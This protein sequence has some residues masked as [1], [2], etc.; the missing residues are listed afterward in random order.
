MN[1]WKIIETNFDMKKNALQESI[2]SLGNGFLGFRGN[3]EEMAS[4]DGTYINGFYETAEMY[5]EEHKT[6]FAKNSETMLNVTAAKSVELSVCG[7]PFSMLGGEVLEHKRELDMLA[8][9]L[10]RKTHWRSPQGNEITLRSRR[11]V[12]FTDKNIAAF[13]YEVTAENFDGYL[14]IKTGVDGDVRNITRAEDNR[15]GSNLKGQPLKVV[16]IQPLEDG[17]MIWQRTE[18]SGLGLYCAFRLETDFPCEKEVEKTDKAYTAKM[19]IKIAAGESAKFFKFLSYSYD[20]E[21]LLK[22][23]SFEDLIV[24]QTAYLKDFWQNSD[25][26]IEHDEEL[27]KSVRFAVFSLLQAVG[28]DGKSSIA[29]K[30]LTGEGYQG[31]YFWESETYMLPVF[32]FTQPEIARSILLYRYSILD[33]ARKLTKEHALEG[34]MYPWRTISGAESS[35]YYPAGTAQYHIT[36]GIAYVIRLYYEVTDD[37]DFMQDYGLEMLFETARMW[38]SLGHFN[39]G[40]FRIDCVTGPDEYTTVVNNNCYTNIIAA[41]NMLFAAE[42]YEK[43]SDSFPQR[44]FFG[45]LKELEAENWRKAAENIYLPYDEERG[46]YKQDDSFLDKKRWNFPNGTGKPTIDDFHPLQVYRAQICKQADLILAE[47]LFSHRFDR[48]QILRDYEYYEPITTHDS[49][50][51]ECVFG[52]VGA[53]IGKFD[54]ALRFFEATAFTDL[55]NTHNN[56]QDGLH[57]A[58]MAGTWLGIVYGFGGFTFRDRRWSFRPYLPKGWSGYSFTLRLGTCSLKVSVD[59]A[60]SYVLTRGEELV[61][62]HNEAEQRVTKG[63]PLRLDI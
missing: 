54:D 41:E 4:L 36:G 20:N 7:E 6:G 17:A 3:L 50:L 12:S 52:I 18:R 23:L 62:F 2:F 14:E 32:A 24:K 45:H 61:F 40:K 5:Y 44:E 56:T 22:G 31:H 13:E 53:R 27:Q 57:M 10:K 33:A 49:S 21:N 51:S 29:A 58:T 26:V 43:Y 16:K 48:E 42:M 8:G 15:V 37:M 60:V 30:G 38:Y 39:K 46:L 35:P 25:V 11:L 9:T 59:D 19:R 63:E 55:H 1:N 47:M 34:A 28:K